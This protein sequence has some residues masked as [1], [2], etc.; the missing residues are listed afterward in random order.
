M[1]KD[2]KIFIEHILDS[3]NAIEEFTKNVNEDEF[4]ANR[5]KMDAVVRNLEI[6]GEATKNLTDEFRL[7]C[8]QIPWKNIAGMRDNLIHEY[9]GVDKVEVWRTVKN[10]IPEL[11]KEM[12]CLL[13][14]L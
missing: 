10:D 12:Q 9:F 2:N 8:S 5:E 6:L 3:I 14:S 1:D 13:K 7:A 4:Y 11:K